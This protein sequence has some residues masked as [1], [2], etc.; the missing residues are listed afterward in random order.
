MRGTWGIISILLCINNTFLLSY[1]PSI[2]P[3][4]QG[5]VFHKPLKAKITFDGDFFSKELIESNL[6]SLRNH[7]A[8]W[9]VIQTSL[10]DEL[11]LFDSLK[12]NLL[13]ILKQIWNIME[14]TKKPEL[15]IGTISE[16][17]HV[18][19]LPILER[20]KSFIQDLEKLKSDFIPTRTKRDLTQYYEFPSLTAKGVLKSSDV[21]GCSLSG[22][23]TPKHKVTCMFKYLNILRAP[24][25][26]NLGSDLLYYIHSWLKLG[27]HPIHAQT[28]ELA[29]I[30]EFKPQ[31]TDPIKIELFKF[32]EH[33]IIQGPSQTQSAFYAIHKIVPKLITLQIQTNDQT[34][35]PSI[36]TRTTEQTTKTTELTTEQPDLNT[37]RTEQNLQNTELTTIQPELNNERTE[38]NLKNTE[39]TTV[40][41]EHNIKTTEH[42]SEN[43][44]LTTELNTE[45]TDQI[46]KHIETNIFET[47]LPRQQTNEQIKI[48]FPELVQEI[49]QAVSNRPYILEKSTEPEH[50]T[51]GE[52]GLNPLQRTTTESTHTDKIKRQTP[53]RTLAPAQQVMLAADKV[54]SA[55]ITKNADA[56]IQNYFKNVID[57]FFQMNDELQDILRLLKS[58]IT[59]QRL[60]VLNTFQIDT[61]KILITEVITST[62]NQFIYLIV[63][64]YE[65]KEKVLK[66]KPIT[67]C[68]LKYC[69]RVNMDNIASVSLD[70]NTVFKLDTC[71]TKVID[72]VPAYFCNKVHEDTECLFFNTDCEFLVTNYV[73]KSHEVF[74]S[75]YLLLTSNENQTILNNYTKLDT[76]SIY[77]ISSKKDISLNINKKIIKLTGV[78][79]ALPLSLVK[80]GYSRA[81]IDNMIEIEHTNINPHNWVNSGLLIFLTCIIGVL[82]FRVC[83]HKHKSVK[84]TQKT[85]N[86]NVKNDYITVNKNIP[87]RELK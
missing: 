69:I 73:V 26:R 74:D 87:L 24:I 13:D 84:F 61:E 27:K 78:E 76:E 30:L 12:D 42:N 32:I 58:K 47:E 60:A 18:K 52:G 21:V 28:A 66:F 49:L 3:I 40:Q 8:D 75:K 20:I 63:Q 1:F 48:T 53:Q 57:A 64:N 55:R 5:T 38:Q 9:L 35:K 23:S 71:Q 41:L 82:G 79:Q 86:K 50:S 59:A 15:K 62:D 70:F 4:D 81:D 31:N 39:L 19:L 54:L 37:E 45:P 44:E 2:L 67:F 36:P 16:I 25:Q 11:Q 77:L 34:Q 14:K 46:T 80:L 22:T 65:H 83:K 33:R 29:R 85:K 7:F 43:P 56:I 68:G 6:A 17:K 51:R 72:S 10:T